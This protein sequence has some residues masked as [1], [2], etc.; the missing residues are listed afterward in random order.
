MPKLLIKKGESVVKK[1]LIP[2]DIEAFTIGCEKGNDITITDD[3]ISFFHLQ[4]E[5]QD[6]N[7]FVRD[8]QSQWGTYVNGKKI[9][10]KTRL[11]HL[12][13]I[14]IGNHSIS[15]FDESPTPAK[16]EHQAAEQPSKRST[17]KDFEQ[18][19]QP[20]SSLEKTPSYNNEIDSPLN[21]SYPTEPA[22][23]GNGHVSDQT[24][25]ERNNNLN[26][27]HS[28]S[29]GQQNFNSTNDY[30]IGNIPSDYDIS[31]AYTSGD[32]SLSTDN[33]YVSEPGYGLPSDSILQNDSELNLAGAAHSTL[34]DAKE[35][36]YL[37]CIH[38]YYIGRKFKI[39]TPET[40]IGRDR[41]LNDIIIKKN[42]K[43][44]LDQSVSRR[45]ATLKFRKNNW[46]LSDKRSKSRTWLNRKEL[47]V[48]EEVKVR[49][50]DEI[51]IK[52]D[53]KSHIFRVVENENWDYSFPRKAGAWYLRNAQKLIYAFS[54]LFILSA[55]VQFSTAFFEKRYITQQ[56]ENL[57]FEEELWAF[58][59]LDARFNNLS[60]QN[61]SIFPATGDVDNDGFL[62]LIY[63]NNKG[64]LSCISGN[65]KELLWS[66]TDFQ[67]VKQIPILLEDLYS[68]G[69]PDIIVVSQESRIH[70]IDGSWGIEISKSPILAGPLTGAP[71]IGD[72]NGD[73][74]Q[75][76]AIASAQNAIYL[77]LSST[78]GFSWSKIDLEYPVNSIVSTGDITNDGLDNIFVGTEKGRLL[79]LD[80]LGKTVMKQ[81]DIN[82]E[83]N[84]AIGAFGQDNQIRHPITVSDVNGD[85]AP[86]LIVSTEQGNL[87]A[88]SGLNINRLWYDVTVADTSTTFGQGNSAISSGDLDGD[89]LPDIIVQS[90]NGNLKAIKG[91]S[92]GKDRKITLWEHHYEQAF[93]GNPILA[94]FN[95]NGTMD[96]LV[97]SQAGIITIFEGASGQIISAHNA[98]AKIESQPLIGCFDK[99]NTLDVLFLKDDGKFYKLRS[100]SSIQNNAVVWGQAYGNGHNTNTSP[101]SRP[102][103]TPYYM[104]MGISVFIIGLILLL[105]FLVIRS[106]K[107]LSYY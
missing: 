88:L 3:A 72:F 64:F 74:F 86:D 36:Y 49:L 60:N 8:L 89:G 25:E 61:F 29:N 78:Q 103:I 45:H 31:N 39:K 58:K 43:G 6:T 44:D 83:L 105:N 55:T 51:E 81:I 100:N 92:G 53:K 40:R 7:Y 23:R 79:I 67:A 99:D 97:T 4:I 35:N 69:V 70:I 15:F 41:K 59:E 95:K 12:D 62:D 34:N 96:V 48:E 106:R 98:G 28:F 37:L 19:E 77:A 68:K 32:V 76:I 94:D 87:L 57:K 102:S 10:T 27:E 90:G 21:D 82:E 18:K 54:I 16:P 91:A 1:L 24:Q 2:D 38:G 107:K 22:S 30:D 93:W 101:Y 17:E 63:V 5:K 46:Y 71:A 42:S 73:G 20:L 85:N 50:N 14:Q 33:H 11:N 52:S 84:K 9:S 104:Q 80:G 65:T 13:N 56:P 47:G 75:D 66:N 26:E